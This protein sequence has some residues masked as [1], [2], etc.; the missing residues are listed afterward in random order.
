MSSVSDTLSLRSLW[1][2]Q[3]KLFSSSWITGLGQKCSFPHYSYSRF[4]WQHLGELWNQ[5]VKF[6]KISIGILNG[7]LNIKISG[8]LTSLKHCIFPSRKK[9]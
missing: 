7:I 2:I 1:E 3:V 5:S 4:L 9:V 8:E 6:L